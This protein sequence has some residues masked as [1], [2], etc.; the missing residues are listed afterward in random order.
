LKAQSLLSTEF[1]QKEFEF[2]SELDFRSKVA[3]KVI[4][5]NDSPVKMVRLSTFAI[6]ERKRESRLTRIRTEEQAYSLIPEK[7]VK[8]EVEFGESVKQRLRFG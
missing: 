7:N 8:I 5:A 4:L 1:K 3:I 2:G 6:E